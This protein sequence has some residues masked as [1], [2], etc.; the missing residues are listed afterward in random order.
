M[1][2][3]TRVAYGTHA[4]D[5]ALWD[6]KKPYKDCPTING[7]GMGYGC[8]TEMRFHP[9]N[10]SLIYTT[11]VDGRFCLQDFEGVCSEVI[12]DMQSCDTDT[13]YC[14]MDLSAEYGLVA[15]GDSH[16]NAALMSLNE[17]HTISKIRRLHKS[18][19]K[20]M[21]FC[22]ARSWMFVTA[23]LDHT[24]KFW[25]I[26][27]L[28]AKSP[29]DSKSRPNPLSVAEHSGLVSSAYFDPILGV[30]LL[31]TSQNGEIR[32]YSPHDLWQNP[33]SVIVHQHRNFQHMT[34]IK[35]TWH[36]L[37]D[38]LCVIGRYPMKEDKDQ[39]RTVDLIDVEKG[40]T[41]GCF[42]NPQLKGIIQ[43]NQFNKS[44]D[45]LASGMGYTGLIWKFCD[46]DEHI[47]S[48]GITA[49]KVTGS[50]AP[51][52]RTLSKRS[53]TKVKEKKMKTITQ[54]EVKTKRKK[55]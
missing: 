41:V 35:A 1:H 55:R 53:G 17:H 11:A 50:T 52:K 26:R 4:G 42:Y 28:K 24:V 27:M 3:N 19:I 37:Y 10:P 21:E 20:Y 34:D 39:N 31:T 13:W 51:K 40:E 47:F 49:C 25:D 16:G 38:D 8:I 29:W 33:T 2:S 6:Y 32:V 45:C 36:P 43:L 30:R 9:D 18:K 22:P 7:V 44:G 46:E 54:T 48:H 14:S 12:L 5:I 15:I 23:S